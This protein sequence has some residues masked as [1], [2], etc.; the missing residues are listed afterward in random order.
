MHLVEKLDLIWMQST[1]FLRVYWRLPLWYRV[2]LQM[3]GARFELGLSLCSVAS[4]RCGICSQA[5][6]AEALGVERKWALYPW[7]MCFLLSPHWDP[8]PGVRG[9]LKQKGARIGSRLVLATENCPGCPQCTAYLDL[10]DCFSHFAQMQICVQVPFVTYSGPLTPPIATP[11]RCGSTLQDR[12]GLHG[13]FACTGAEA[14]AARVAGCFQCS[15]WV[16]A[17]DRHPAPPRLRLRYGH[18]SI[19]RLIFTFWH[20]NILLIMSAKWDKCQYPFLK[21]KTAFLSHLVLSFPF[22]YLSIIGVLSPLF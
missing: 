8:C 17:N 4:V 13:L 1:S 16:R 5:V 22:A 15:A 18:L 14:T 6:V 21:I 9:M 7:C 20:I 3:E 11:A 19:Y 2:W 10:H 12:Q